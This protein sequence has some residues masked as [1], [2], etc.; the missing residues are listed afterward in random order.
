M[1]EADGG[2]CGRSFEQA[3]IL[4]N[5]DLFELIEVSGLARE[6]KAW[7]RAGDVKD[8]SAFALEYAIDKTGWSVPRYI[9]EGLR[10]LMEGKPGPTMPTP[11]IVEDGITSVNTP[12]LK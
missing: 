3:F 1:P 2:P 5:P 6:E 7:A 11:S 9:A 10:W 4:A 8:K 12:Q